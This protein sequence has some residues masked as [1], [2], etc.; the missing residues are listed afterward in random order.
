MPLLPEDIAQGDGETA[1][2]ADADQDGR[3]Q[4]ISCHVRGAAIRSLEQADIL[5]TLWRTVDY[6]AQQYTPQDLAGW[7][8]KVLLVMADDDPSTP[9]TVRA[10]NE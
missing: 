8:G 2:M 10:C 5:S 6:Y 9:E 3:D 7:S 4:L 1:Q